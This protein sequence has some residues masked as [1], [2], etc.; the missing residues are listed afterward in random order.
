MEILALIPA[1]GGSKGIPKK[2]IYP[3]LGKPLI[4]YTIEELRKCT[5]KMTIAVSTDSEEIKKVVNKYR[6]V[7]VI[8]RPSEIAGDNATT[9]S[10]MLHALDHFATVRKKSFDCILLL[11]ATSPLRKS[12]TIDKF[13]HSYMAKRPEYDA[14]LTLAPD[15]TDFWIQNADGE[16]SRLFPNAPRRRQNR[17]P[18]Y[19]ENSCIYITDVDALRRTS[20][21]MGTHCAGFIMDCEEGLD[22]NNR[23]DLLIAEAYLRSGG[24]N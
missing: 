24:T 11:Q 5:T 10:A 20:S 12:K 14:Q 9:E 7:I 21:I 8:D 16:F 17:K 15:T 22:I 1:R 19:A 4:E 18:L 13:I 6:G 3:L 23:Q 2:N